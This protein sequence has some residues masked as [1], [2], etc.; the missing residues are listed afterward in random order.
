MKAVVLDMDERVLKERERQGLDKRD[1][2]WEGVLHLVPPPTK[3]HQDVENELAVALRAAARRRGWAVRTDMG[4]FADVFD[5]RVPDI[6]VY[7]PEAASARGVD[8]PP[9][10]VI[11][12]RS[13][14]DES[15][16][17]ISWYLARGTKAV[18]VV[19]QSSL[20]L[21]LHTQQGRVIPDED[22]SVLLEPL[23]VRL[24]PS[25]GALYVD[26]SALEL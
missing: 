4:V 26:G 11:E 7:A 21:E 23:G 19:D 22:G 17:K 8:G 5:Y 12:V 9:E 18:L 14:G 20:S 2:M 6:V 16:E 10:V 1:E 24:T 13:P 25:P 15:Y 3:R